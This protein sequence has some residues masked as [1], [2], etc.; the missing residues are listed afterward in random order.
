MRVP[1]VA[2]TFAEAFRT[3]HR[4]CWLVGG[5]VR[6]LVMRRPLTDLDIATDAQPEEVRRMFRTVIPTGIKHGTVTVIFKNIYLAGENHLQIGWT[7]DNGTTL[8][9]LA[10]NAAA[11]YR[12]RA[13]VTLSET[14]AA[15]LKLYFSD[16]SCH[17]AGKAQ[18]Y[19]LSDGTPVDHV[20]TYV[21][22][23]AP[24][25]GTAID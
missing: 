24:K 20:A 17:D 15:A 19:Y 8:N 6:D 25:R 9:L 16:V 1:P 7:T 11:H 14:D 12:H 3:H 18:D 22:S 21:V 4:Q 23:P 2:R 5:A 10:D 13:R